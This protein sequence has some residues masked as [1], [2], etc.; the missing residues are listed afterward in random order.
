MKL[1]TLQGIIKRRILVNYRAEPET[2]QKILPPQ[3]RPKTFN[4]KAIAGICLIRLE[5]IRPQFAPEFVGISSENAAHRIAVEWE[6]NGEKREGVFIPRRD[7]DSLI[8]HFGGGTIFPGEH[9]SADFSVT[10]SADKIDFSMKSKDEKVQLELKGSVSA[11]L[12]RNS[13]FSSIAE[14]SAFFEK[15]SL[16]YSVTKNGKDLDGIYLEIED[17]QVE[18]LN[19]DSIHSNFYEDQTVFPAGS[20]EFDHA[21]LMRDIVHK[22]QSAPSFEL[23]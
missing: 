5:R 4:G 14:A 6:E 12:P 17:W 21:L 16:G 1:P 13:I 3:F 22:W 11:D 20:I 15:G 2:I 23:K 18:A 9:H 8:N 19:L 7:T 10:E